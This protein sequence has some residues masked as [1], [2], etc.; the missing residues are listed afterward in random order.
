MLVG[1]DGEALTARRQNEAITYALPQEGTMLWGDS[2]VISAKSPNRHTAELFLNFL[3]RPEVGAQIIGAYF[4]P[5]ANEAA[6][7]LVDAKLA[8]DPLV[9][10]S[11]DVLKNAEW[12]SALSPEGEKLYADTWQRFMDHFQANIRRE[13]P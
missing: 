3:L 6:Y 9:N 4:Y 2:W 1:W 13:A 8:N 5:S 7:S 12:F 10:P 11:R